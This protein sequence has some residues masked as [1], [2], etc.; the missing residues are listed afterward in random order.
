[1]RADMGTPVQVVNITAGSGRGAF[2]EL[3]KRPADGCT[4]LALTSDYLVLEAIHGDEVDLGQLTLL[5]RAHAELGLLSARGDA[6]ARWEDIVERARQDNRR[7]LVGGTG[8]KSFDRTAVDITLGASDIA[9]RYIPYNG[10]KEMQADLLGGRLDA[11]YDEYGVMKPLYEAGVATPL[12]VMSD[13]PLARLNTVPT[14]TA[15]GL[16][17][18]PAI[19]RGIG[20]HAETQETDKLRLAKATARALR[21]DAY[22]AYEKARNL[23]LLE[24]RLD[25]PAFAHALAQERGAFQAALKG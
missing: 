8:A 7:V 25:G 4:L 21:S 5:A 23:D 2:R 3:M 24:G 17:A 1:M 14:A 13:T 18:A 10:T 22:V 16:E 12:L 9:Y 6:P 11:V 15:L 20:I 19:W